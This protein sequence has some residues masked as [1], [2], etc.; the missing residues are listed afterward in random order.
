MPSEKAKSS[1][2]VLWV[3]PFKHSRATVRILLC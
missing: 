3:N 2:P 1:G